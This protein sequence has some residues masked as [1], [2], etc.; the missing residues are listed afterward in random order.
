MEKGKI[1]SL[2]MAMM[3]YPAVIATSIIS[4]P[5][6]IAKYARNDLWLPPIIASF[7]GFLTVYIAFELHKRYPKQT[8]I[9]LS[10]QILGK[11]AGKLVSLCILSF[12]LIYTG[13]IIRGYS[14]FIVSSFLFNTPISVIMVSM[15]ML[16]AFTVFGGIEVLGRIAQLFFPLFVIPILFCVLLLSPDFE[17]K[18]IFPI[19]GGGIVSSSQGFNSGICM[20]FG[21][22]L[23]D[24]F[25][26]FCSRCE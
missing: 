19:L 8:V 24:F 12:Y 3:L 13:H 4:A 11:F 25:S 1:S 2:Q 20:V 6:I 10:E 7:L 18:N 26:A 5:S 22:F 9:Q 21:I 16:C 15:I 23:D 17:V 14:E